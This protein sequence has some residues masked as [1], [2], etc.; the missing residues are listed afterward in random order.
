MKKLSQ[1]KLAVLYK[2]NQDWISKAKARGVD[3]YDKGAVRAAM[4]S[5]AKRPKAWIN[6]CWWDDKPEDN[7]IVTTELNGDDT[8]QQIKMLEA[9]ALAAQDYETSR[10]FRTKIQSLKELLQLQILAG[11]YTH[12]DQ[13]KEDYTKIGHA[14][15]A[16]ALRQQAELPGM[17]EGLTAAQMKT[18]IKESSMNLLEELKMGILTNETSKLYK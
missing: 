7:P 17:L 4:L 11:E 14:V 5:Q 18:R 10:F 15:K 16:S 3:I 13:I 8:A 12:K 9:Q 1:A 6:G 2:V